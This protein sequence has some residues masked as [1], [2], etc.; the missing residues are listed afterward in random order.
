MVR[1]PVVGSSTGSPGPG[2]QLAAHPVQLAD[3][4]P[5]EAA[6]EGPQ[7]GG[8][9]DYAAERASRTA[10][11]RHVGIVDAVSASQRRSHQGHHLV[12][13]IGSARRVAQVQVPVN[14]LRQAQ[15]PAQRGWQDQP[16]IGHQ[17][18]VVKG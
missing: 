10:S 11:A 9:L 15:I 5:P 8:G 18:V 13:R 17:A 2:Q 6:Q 3:V 4:A 1:G 12:A 16:S 14:Q 7:G